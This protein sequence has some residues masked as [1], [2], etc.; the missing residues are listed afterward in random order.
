[1]ELHGTSFSLLRSVV[2]IQGPDERPTSA[3]SQSSRVQK[4]T[5]ANFSLDKADD[6]INGYNHIDVASPFPSPLSS[7]ATG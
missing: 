4:E 3:A 2:T 7:S 1:M 6:F 5:C